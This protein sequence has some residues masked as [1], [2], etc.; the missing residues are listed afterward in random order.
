M[1][2]P[3]IC[4]I[5]VIEIFFLF[6]G[7]SHPVHVGEELFSRLSVAV[8]ADISWM[9]RYI[10]RVVRLVNTSPPCIEVRKLSP[11]LDST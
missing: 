7:E 1:H 8:T 9:R 3:A 4:L 10:I 5:L 11:A 6:V 2:V